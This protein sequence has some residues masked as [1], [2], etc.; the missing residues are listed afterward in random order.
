M[1]FVSS[2][3]FKRGST[4]DEINVSL[5]LLLNG[6]VW[7]MGGVVEVV[8]HWPVMWSHD[9]HAH[10]C[11]QLAPKEPSS[12]GDSHLKY[13]NLLFSSHRFDD[14]LIAGPAWRTDTFSGFCVTTSATTIAFKS[15]VFAPCEIVTT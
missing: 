6:I 8:E 12:H 13:E 1:I 3:V 5:P 10:F 14:L 9:A 4:V 7:T 2:V 11:W 15:T